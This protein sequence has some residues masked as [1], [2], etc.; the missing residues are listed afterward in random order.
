MLLKRASCCGIIVEKCASR[1]RFDHD[2]IETHPS[3]ETL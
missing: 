1:I 3:G 2:L